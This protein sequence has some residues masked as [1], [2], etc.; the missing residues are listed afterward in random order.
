MT[1]QPTP[2]Q[3]R[4]PRKS[5]PAGAYHSRSDIRKEFAFFEIAPIYQ[6]TAER[7]ETA[8]SL[9]A[10]EREIDVAPCQNVEMF[11]NDSQRQDI[12][13]YS[14]IVRERYVVWHFIGSEIRLWMSGTVLTAFHR[15]LIG[16]VLQI[17]LS[18]SLFLVSDT[19]LFKGTGSI[20]FIQPRTV[21]RG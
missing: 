19:G 18:R 9:I 17:A 7:E 11:H 2:R 13:Y 1:H 5:R 10:R 6:E 14:H 21:V 8:Y 3:M 20:L 4:A 16:V 12:P 15:G